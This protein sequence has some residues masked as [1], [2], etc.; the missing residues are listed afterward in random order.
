M[1][2]SPDFILQISLVYEECPVTQEVPENTR[3]V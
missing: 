2:V 3:L 1:M